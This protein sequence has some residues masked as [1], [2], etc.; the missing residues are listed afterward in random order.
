MN[1]FTLLAIGSLGR[2]PDLTTKGEGTCTRFCLVGND[3]VDGD[4]EG[5]PREIVTSAWFV[6][7]GAI[8]D[9]IARQARKG[10]SAPF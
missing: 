6:A 7:Y 8:G 10:V 9:A 4:E 5:G 3:Y 2:N 1:S